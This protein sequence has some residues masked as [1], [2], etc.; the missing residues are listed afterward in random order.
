MRFLWLSFWDVQCTGKRYGLTAW[1][2][3]GN[4]YADASVLDSLM[5]QFSL[6]PD[7]LTYTSCNL[8]VSS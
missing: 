4:A 7:D 6:L 2:V 3:E 5:N 1:L 8:L